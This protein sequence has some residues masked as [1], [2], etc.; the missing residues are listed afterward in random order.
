MKNKPEVVLYD[1]LMG[2]E[3]N[4][5]STKDWWTIGYKFSFDEDSEGPRKIKWIYGGGCQP[6]AVERMREVSEEGVEVALFTDKD[7]ISPMV[8]K[9]KTKYKVAFLGECRSIHP[10]AYDLILRVENKFDYI[11]TFDDKLLERGGKYVSGVPPAGTCLKRE[12]IGIHPKSKF[13]AL[14]ASETGL[15]VVV[16]KEAKGH[17][18]RHIIAR[19]LKKRKYDV[20]LWGRAYR[21]FEH[22]NRIV[23]LKDYYFS[24][25]IMNAS[26][27]N[28][29]TDILTDC[30]RT[31]TVPIFWGCEN[32]GEFFNEKGIISFKTPEQLNKIISSLTVKDYY[33]RMEYIQENFER[34]KEYFCTDDRLA[35]QMIKQGIL[36]GGGK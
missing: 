3:C 33:D 24:F 30:F 4:Y 19:A 6:C 22:G 27:K 11:F 2:R 8:D 18:L 21:P 29:F 26:H 14:I 7:I 17:F 15:D 12:H 23:S 32:V 35:E 9:I 10:W 28:Y 25:A 13:S 16:S 34:V 36:K 31:G 1:S 5:S 20:D